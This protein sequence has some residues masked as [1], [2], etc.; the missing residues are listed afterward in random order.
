M[1]WIFDIPRYFNNEPIF[2]IMV[3]SCLL[4]NGN[5]TCTYIHFNILLALCFHCD[6][7]NVI[8]AP[9]LIGISNLNHIGRDKMRAISDFPIP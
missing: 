1:K 4:E 3:R 9:M 7:N 8:D 2:Q 5:Q 6:A